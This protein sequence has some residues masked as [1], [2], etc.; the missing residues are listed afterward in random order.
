MVIAMGRGH[1]AVRKQIRNCVLPE[2]MYCQLEL[3]ERKRL[4]FANGAEAHFSLIANIGLL[5]RQSEYFTRTRVG[6][7]SRNWQG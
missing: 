1:A 5:G 3:A 6:R 7:E 2:E 4:L